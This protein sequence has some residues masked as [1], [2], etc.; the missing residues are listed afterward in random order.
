V[1][2][3]PTKIAPGAYVLRVAQGRRHRDKEKDDNNNDDMAQFDVTIGAAGPKGDKGDMGPAGPQG[4]AGPEGQRGPQGPAGP[5]GN[6][7]PQGPAGPQGFPG[8]TG[9]PGAEG[10]KGET[11]PPGPQGPPGPG[12]NLFGSNTNSAAAGNGRFCDL[13]SIILSAA[14]VTEGILANGQTLQIAQNQALF[15]LYGTRF[16]GDGKTTFGVPDLRNAAPN[17]LTYSICDNGTAPTKR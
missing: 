9:L 11:G 10:P 4:P 3:A 1:T 12:S 15:G 2:V 8:L 7:G 6:T 5:Q 17:G 14:N 13:G 16:G